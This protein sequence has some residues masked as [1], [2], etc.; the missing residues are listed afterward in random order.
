LILA[1]LVRPRRCHLHAGLSSPKPRGLWVHW[2]SDVDAGRLIGA[3]V[4]A[5]CTAMNNSRLHC[6]RHARRLRRRVV[7]RQPRNRLRRAG[8]TGGCRADGVAMNQGVQRESERM[9]V[10]EA[11]R[12]RTIVCAAASSGARRSR[13]KWCARA[14]PIPKPPAPIQPPEKVIRTAIVVFDVRRVRSGRTRGPI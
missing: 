1:E 6:R 7:R 12:T 9:S 14:A 5:D 11:R 10:G 2:Q 8:G 13:A 3:A 4:V